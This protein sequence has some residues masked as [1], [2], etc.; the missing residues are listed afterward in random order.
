MLEWYFPKLSNY[1]IPDKLCTFLIYHQLAFFRY[2]YLHLLSTDSSSAYIL[3]RRIFILENRVKMTKNNKKSGSFMN[4]EIQIQITI[5]W[6]NSK[7]N[8][9]CSEFFHSQLEKIM[10]GNFKNI[11]VLL[12]PIFIYMLPYPPFDSW[13]DQKSFILNSQV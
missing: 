1:P 7:K 12:Y 6:G 13:V 11:F 2:V 8:I 3:F 4:K 9:Y 10:S 5:E